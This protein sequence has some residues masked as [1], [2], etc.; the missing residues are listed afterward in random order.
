MNDTP[1]GSLGRC[2]S[3]D[4][5]EADLG[6]CV[7][8]FPDVNME[9]SAFLMSLIRVRWDLFGLYRWLFGG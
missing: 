6:R 1:E 9:L 4:A 5:A 8:S 7:L 3:F 2:F